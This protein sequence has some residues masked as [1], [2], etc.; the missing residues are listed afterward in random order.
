MKLLAWFHSLAANFLHRPQVEDDM[1]EE[2]RAHIQYRAD[3]LERSGLDR[4]EAERRARIEFGGHERFKEECRETLAGNLVETLVRDVR[5]SIRVLRKS[6]G[7]ATVAVVTLALAIGANAVVFGVLNGLILRPLNVPQAESLYGTEYGDGSGWQ[8]YPNYLDLRDR[9]RSFEAL[10]AF[11]F[12]FVGLDT[13]K[14]PSRAS[15][16]AV[17]GNYFDVLRVYPY[18]GRFFHSSDEHGPNSAPY[19]VLTYGYW[20]THFQ[21]DRGVLGRVI[22]LN[23]HPFTI[24][25]VAQPGFRGTSLFVSPDFFMPI[26]NEEQASGEGLLNVRGS[27]HGVFEA[28]GHLKPGVT[29][30]QAVA[31]VNA[32]GAYLERT[33][34]KEFPHKRSSLSLQGLTSFRRPAEAFVAG[35]MLLAGLILLAACANLGSLFAAHAADRSREVALRLALGSSRRRILRQ[36]L[37]EAVLISLVGGAAGL[38]GGVVLLG[39]LSAWQPFSGTGVHLPTEPDAAVCLLAL[40]LAL[41]SGFL[42]GIVPVRQVLRTDPYQIVKAGSTGTPG[43]RLTVRDLLLGLQIAIC[44]VLVTSSM[45]AVRGLARS[46]HAN[47]GFEPRN[48]MLVSV[49]LAMV[50]YSVERVPDMQKRMIGA[51]ETIPGVERAGLV[52]GYPPL[53]YAAGSRTN[54]FKDETIDLRQSNTAA[55]PYEYECAGRPAWNRG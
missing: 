30:A 53:V 54:V 34:P 29:P 45:V 50:G 32:V 15:G 24:V 5:F 12:V 27:T 4:A 43:R 22:R 1:E 25:G 48:T 14:S 44:A 26:V 31:D 11:N 21:D 17:T 38:L 41:V 36:L 51:L 6:P 46:L 28:M 42:F 18:L 55:T 52:N 47:F 20:H 8:S 35:L 16:F 2:L 23:K 7:F 33:Y 3:D 13:G 9:N 49:N 37:T 39:R 40:A 10:A 19:I